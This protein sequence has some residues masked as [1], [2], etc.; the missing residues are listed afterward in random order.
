MDSGNDSPND[1][2]FERDPADR[3]AALPG[4]PGAGEAIVGETIAA[5]YVVE[6]LLG[7]N[8]LVRTYRARSEP[9]GRR[10]VVKL[11]GEAHRDD[12]ALAR[13]VTRE[14]EAL[15]KLDHPH[16][17]QVIEVTTD[18]RV[19]LVVCR[20]LV[21][22]EDLISAARRAPLTPRRVCELLMQLLSGLAE[23]HRNGILH[24]NLK[25][26][27]VFVV[28][29]ESGRESLK[30][31]D[32]GSLSDPRSAAEYRAPEQAR[33]AGGRSVDGQADV[34]SAGVLLYE[35]LTEDVPFRAATAE[36]TFA[37]HVSTEV[38]APSSKRPD[39]PLP[40]ELEAVC[41]K[42]LAKQPGERHRSPREMSQALR[43][44]IALLESRVDEPLGSSAFLP[45]GRRV[46]LTA[47]SERMTMPGEHIRS[48]TKFWLGALLIA[49]VCAGVLLTPD[50]R[51]EGPGG[52]P[53]FVTGTSERISAGERALERG[54]ARLK[55]GDDVP[56]AIEELEAARDALG[57]TP[58]VMRALGEALVVQG[59]TSEGIPMLERYL[60]L[61]PA[62]PDRKFLE[63]LINT[64][65]TKK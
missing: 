9:D 48:H 64:E 37:Q 43:A 13:R 41:L 35:L 11:L 55:A 19:G 2:G 4:A 20:E 61:E 50:R 34:Y 29:D 54:V 47:S 58:E 52:L 14:L 24:R 33:A 57:E 23:A 51:D 22:G 28:R 65:A 42:A 45:G 26:Q 30:L 31:C 3:S 15:R 8:T 1:E 25:P 53:P 21:D 7:Q 18:E 44:V 59:N 62:T 40:R 16:I 46:A 32:F 60:E 63:S 56:G 12:V 49:A 39:R 10:V 38:P 17:A 6:G 5:R 27:N 36:Q